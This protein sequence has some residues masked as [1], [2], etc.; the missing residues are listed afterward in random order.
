ME[1]VE[2]EKH[3]EGREKKVAAFQATKIKKHD[4]E[5]AALEKKLIHQR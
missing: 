1:V 4:I 5:R 2:Q 3:M